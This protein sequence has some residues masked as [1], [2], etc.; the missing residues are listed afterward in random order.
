MDYLQVKTPFIEKWEKEM[1]ELLSGGKLESD[2]F[3]SCLEKD[4]QDEVGPVFSLPL[5]GE[6]IKE[7]SNLFSSSQQAYPPSAPSKPPSPLV[8]LKC[9]M[10]SV[11]SL[12]L[13][14]DDPYR[15]QQRPTKKRKEPESEPIVVRKEMHNA[16]EK[17][18][19]EK[20]NDKINELKEILPQCKTYGSN[21]ASILHHAVEYIKV[22]QSNNSTLGQANTKLQESNTQLVGEMRNLH[23]TLCSKSNN[24]ERN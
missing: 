14:S 5:F 8:N 6:L 2:S 1:E 17:R 16:T 11:P 10:D 22:L 13:M 12:L 7:S 15:E 20:I 4:V 21:K 9:S 23:R 18:R 24:D 3:F 19:R